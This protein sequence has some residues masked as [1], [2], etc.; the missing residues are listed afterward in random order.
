MKPIIISS[1]VAVGI[2]YAT[3]FF[4]GSSF[5]GDSEGVVGTVPSKQE[6][7]PSVAV[8]DGKQIITINV[9]GGY[10]PKISTAKAG[11]PTVIRFRTNGTF[12]CSSALRIPSLGVQ[13]SLPSTGETDI[14]IG[15]QNAGTLS[16]NC[17]MGMYH[18]Q[19]RFEG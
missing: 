13:K 6:M 16:G 19:V 1:V 17:S 4:T 18:F 12:D 9:K 11:V 15:V 3:F 10:S 14:E 5:S 8:V 7:V 2:L